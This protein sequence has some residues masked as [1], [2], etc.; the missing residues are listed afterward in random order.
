[1]K[2]G[3]VP[4]AQ[5]EGGIVVHSIRKDGLVLKKGTRV[6]KDEIAALNAAKIASI[7]VARLEPED[8]SEDEAAADI[9]KAVA[10]DGVR[11]EDAFTGRSN[12]FAET[13]GLLVVDRASIDAL[14]EVDPD[15]T[16]ATLDA[17]APVV[18]GKMLAT[19][20]I[21]PFALGG[22]ARDA[23]VEVATKSK[24]LVRVAP[25][26]I[27]KVGIISTLLPG[28]ADKVI[29]KTLQVTADRLAPAGAKIV[30]EKRVPH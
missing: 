26:T 16:L 3:A 17:F 7:T 24:P 19:V 6:G 18:P 8:I 10:G 25:Y 12:L 14:N 27:K 22:A 11:V 5:A 9:A 28:L 20:K 29:E 23:A 1:M 15:I 2:F 4:P 21:I 13:A 30:A